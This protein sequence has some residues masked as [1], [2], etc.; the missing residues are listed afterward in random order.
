MT[1]DLDSNHELN[2]CITY[3]GFKSLVYL[4][5]KSI[6][7]IDEDDRQSHNGMEKLATKLG[8]SS[9]ERIFAIVEKDEIQRV[10]NKDY[11]CHKDFIFK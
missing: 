1:N 6:V 10:K 8:L 7:L 4:G 9:I 2:H 5:D 11:T 3:N